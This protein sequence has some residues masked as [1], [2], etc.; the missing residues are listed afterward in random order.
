MFFFGGGG[1]GV[2]NNGANISK[3][4]TTNLLKY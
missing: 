3:L 1:G 2:V 4:T